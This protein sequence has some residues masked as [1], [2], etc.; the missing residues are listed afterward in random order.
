MEGFVKKFRKA[1][2]VVVWE[3]S[4]T[5]EYAIP[6]HDD[7][8]MPTRYQMRGLE[9]KEL[10]YW[11]HKAFCKR[12]GLVNHAME[13]VPDDGDILGKNRWGY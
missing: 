11:E 2:K 4:L 1:G 9:R 5:G 6:M 13:D 7:D 12:H 8:P 10:N 3:N